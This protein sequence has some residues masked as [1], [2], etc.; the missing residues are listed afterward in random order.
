MYSL[1]FVMQR[2]DIFHILFWLN[3]QH[4]SVESTGSNRIDGCSFLH[5]VSLNHL[6]VKAGVGQLA[7]PC[8]DY[9]MFCPLFTCASVYSGNFVNIFQMVVN[10]RAVYL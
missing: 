5:N 8:S 9:L 10:V 7:F 2:K 3:W 4:S 6:G 1:T